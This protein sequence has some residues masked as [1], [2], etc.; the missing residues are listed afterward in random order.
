MAAA[1]ARPGS[2]VGMAGNGGVKGYTAGQNVEYYSKSYDE[3][4]PC[5]IGDVRSDGNLRLLHDD[6][7]VLKEQADSSL[8]RT[9]ANSNAGTPGARGGRPPAGGPVAKK[10]GAAARAP[11]PRQQLGGGPPVKAGGGPAG[12]FTPKAK[13]PTPGGGRPSQG[14]G[15]GAARAGSQEEGGLAM[16]INPRKFYVGDK[17]KIKDSGREGE[18]MYVGV[19]SFSSKEIVGMKLDEKRSKS[20]CDGKA[21]NG[22][23]LFRCPAGYG[24]FLPSEDVEA[25]PRDEEE[26]FPSV[27]APDAKLDTASAFGGLIGLGAAKQALNKVRQLVEVQKKRE[28]LGVLGGKPLHF[29]F[30]GCH[31]SGMSTV[32]RLLAHLLRDL[33]VL[34][35]G[36]LT[37]VNRKELLSGCKSYGDSDKQMQKLWQA[38]TGGVLLI[39]DIHLMQ[40]R[41]RSRDEVGVEACES[42][43]QQLNS[44]SQKSSV[45]GA[46]SCWP[47]AVC[48]VITSPCD[49]QLPDCLQKLAFSTI[50]FPDFTKEELGDI[51]IHLV[52]KRKFTL[53]PKLTA[54]AL[55]P[56]VRNACGRTEGDDKNINLLQKMLDEAIARQTERVWSTETVSLHGLMSLSEEDFMDS[57][58]ASREDTI[59]AALQ[60]LENVVGLKGVKTFIQSLYAQLKTEME[61]RD[62]GIHVPGGVGTIHM[63][64]TG[65][66]GTGKT[67]VARIVAELLNAM[68]L[69]RKGHMVEADRGA[70]VAGYSGQTAIKTRGVVES[71]MGG[72]LFI[73]EAY[74]LVA[75]DG[76]DA[77][78]HE[79]LDTLLKMIEDRRG[80]LVVILAGYPDEMDRLLSANPGLRSRFPVSVVFEDYSEEELMQIAEKMLLDDVLVLSHGGT[81]ALAKILHEQKASCPSG[82][83]HGNGRA[84]RNILEKAKRNMAVRLQEGSNESRKRT[85]A[86]LCT[87]EAPDFS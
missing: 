40:D 30:R 54:E 58:S 21:P 46:G 2:A 52:E 14:N 74:A 38:A 80:D 41:E 29:A 72:V 57:M 10:A 71:A 17:A 16:T 70:L 68:G 51:L 69:L 15:L 11:S 49:S 61:R 12:G 36:Q 31:G 75:D 26:S 1:R 4:I 50:E 65:N 27:P 81:E 43:A 7:S 48:V 37:E 84:V 86:E 23:R 66:P 62:A 33:D 42:I 22:E 53:A 47:Q 28:E 64:F 82:R 24:I 56:Y 76:K 34:G 45:E 67:T 9:P 20:D 87:L 18:V 8:V 73:D 32:A 6:G 85:Q 77:F 79:A 5:V 35:S 19:P 3:W 55:A 63:V 44:L 25:C 78:G 83:E 60:K 39:N 13:A 59:R